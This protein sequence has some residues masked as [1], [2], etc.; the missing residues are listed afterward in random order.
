MNLKWDVISRQGYQFFGKISASISHDIKNILAIIGENTG[1]LQDLVAMAE[2]GK[3]LDPDRL[4]TLTGKVLEQVRRADG[5]VRDLNR[6]AHSADEARGDVNVGETVLFVC[7]LSRR[8]ASM[9]GIELQPE[10]G[11]KLPAIT[12][13]PFL[14]ENLLWL[15]LDFA[16]EAVGE[17]SSLTILSEKAD[18]GARVRFTGLKSLGSLLDRDF[19]GTSEK[20]LLEALNAEIHVNPA[21]QEVALSLPENL[22]P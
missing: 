22:E 10:S 1:L 17:E 2:K 14:L 11:P 6:F 4:K 19:P 20:A 9:R 18:Q 16:M 13:N 5:I 3:S 21:G 7:A 15:C 12:T 8:L